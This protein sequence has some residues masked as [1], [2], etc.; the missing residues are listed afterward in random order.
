M[1]DR[2]TKAPL[3][4]DVQA[5]EKLSLPEKIKYLKEFVTALNASL[6]SDAPP[7]QGSKKKSG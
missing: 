5:F 4:F 2:L 7:Y 1:P 3:K 6:A